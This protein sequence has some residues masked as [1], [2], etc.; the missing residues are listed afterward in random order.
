MPPP[1]VMTI[2]SL[3]R[4]HSCRFEGA[5]ETEALVILNSKRCVQG[6]CFSG[7]VETGLMVRFAD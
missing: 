6:S 1:P 3:Y 4:F 7:R 5:G 2:A